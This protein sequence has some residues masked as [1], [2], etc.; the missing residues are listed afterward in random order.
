[1]VEAK[2]DQETLGKIQ[3]F[4]QSRMDELAQMASQGTSAEDLE[5]FVDQK[6][7]EWL[8]CV[9]LLSIVFVSLYVCII[10]FIP[11]YV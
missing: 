11:V 1:L 5:R 3:E 2:V 4:F 8:L 10:V 7:D 9:V 6:I